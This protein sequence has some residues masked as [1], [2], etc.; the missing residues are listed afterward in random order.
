M[1]T[2]IIGIFVCT[3]LIATALPAVG[4]MNVIKERQI[5]STFINNQEVD[6]ENIQSL[7]DL[8]VE[9]ERFYGGPNMDVFRYVEQTNDGGYIMVGAWNGTSHW[10]VKVD[11]NGDEEWSATALTNAT[12]Y[13][14]CFIVEQTSDGGFITA[15]CHEK[16]TW[17]YNRCIWKVDENGI[18][19]WCKIYDD[20]LNGYHTCI[21]ET[22]D[23]GY[24]VCGEEDI[25]PSDWDVFLMKTD[26]EGN[27][28]WQKTHKYG[29]FGDIAY[30]VRQTPDGGY[31]LSGRI[32]TSSSTADFLIIKTDSNGDIEWDKTYGGD[33]WEQSNSNDILLTSDGGY[34]F[35]ADT[36]SYGPGQ[37]DAWLI[38]TDAQGNMEWNKTFGGRKRDLSGGMD[39]TNDGGII[40][41]VTKD[42]N[43]FTTPKGEGLVIKTDV[44]GNLEWQHIFGYEK[45]DQLQSVCSTSDG[46]YIVAGNTDSTDTHGAGDMDAWLI[47]IKAFENNPPEKPSKPTGNTECEPGK[48][49]TFTT[50]CNDPDGDDVSFLWDWG[51]GEES[52][53]LDTDDASHN[54]SEYGD[55]DI[56]VM[57]KD[58]HGAESDWSES[59]KISIPRPRFA[60]KPLFIL[61][62]RYQELF[63]ILKILLQR[64]RM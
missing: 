13:P 26:S 44:N 8:E 29:E 57:A 62:Q 24:I 3:L 7:H 27:V 30:A 35:Q 38:K 43:S 33:F 23:G 46:G 9:W 54:W 40:I 22:N 50:S 11:A 31:I 25:T 19:E 34:L 2:K 17:G 1:K 20:P 58:E 55:Y 36:Q 4:T 5:A 45:E 12:H 28:E 18:T 56:K 61:F 49:Y 39:F 15:G 37:L 59:L 21:Q 6:K 47:K 53:W 16:D 51:D 48:D 41:T 52:E 60:N 32:E 42:F 14:R 10:L 63:P 64:L